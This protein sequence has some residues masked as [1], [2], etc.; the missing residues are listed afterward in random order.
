MFLVVIVPIV[1]NRFRLLWA[2]VSL[3]KKKTTGPSP[4]AQQNGKSIANRYESK[5]NEKRPCSTREGNKERDAIKCF[6]Y[7]LAEHVT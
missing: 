4:S 2:D 5:Y 6:A 1:T 3:R 7:H